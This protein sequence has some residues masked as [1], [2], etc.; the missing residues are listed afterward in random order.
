MSHGVSIAS[1]RSR[2]RRAGRGCLALVLGCLALGGAAQAETYPARPVKIVVPF[3]PGSGTDTVTRLLAQQLE[4][5]LKQPVTVENRPGANGAIAASAVAR[6]TPDGLTLLMGTNSTH[7]ANPG[8]IAKMSYDP[9]K[10]FAPIGMVAT[11]SSFL[12]VHPSLPVKT[13]AELVAYAKAHPKALSFAAG[14]T[15]SLMMGEMFARR[16]GIELL[17]VPY[18]SNPAGL[19]DVIA[20]RVQLMFPDM[21][22]SNA[23][24]KAGSVRALAAVTL[25]GRSP[26]APD[27]PTLSETLLPDFNFIGWIGLFAPQG[28][29][30][31]AVRRV[32]EETERILALPEIAQRM[33]QLGA[34]TRWMGPTEFSGLVRSE[35]ARLPKLLQDIGVQPQ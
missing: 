32:A 4:G 18:T 20:G 24:V 31:A 26:L 1:A 23:H 7:G 16:A 35:V 27:L 2:L 30:E 19:T 14:N 15:S 34:E 28:T 9:V 17:R 5:A 6:A 11:F 8:L 13:S 22:S 12:V 10:D 29:P 25:G 33:Q 21:A 3:G